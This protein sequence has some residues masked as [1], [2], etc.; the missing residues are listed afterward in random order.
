[1]LYRPASVRLSG[2]GSV[3]SGEGDR[4][5]LEVGSWKTGDGRSKLEDGG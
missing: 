5:M 3:K 4:A 1:M 2:P